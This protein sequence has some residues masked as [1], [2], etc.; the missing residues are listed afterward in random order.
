MGFCCRLGDE[1]QLK[2]NVLYESGN[3][4]VVPTIGQMG[5]DGYVLLCSKEH[6]IG[7]GD[8]PK[9]HT[10]ELESV[11]GRIKKV[12]SETYGSE[13]LVF[14]H[15][16]R[17]GCHKGGGCLDHGHLHIIPTSIDIMEFLQ[18]MFKPEEIQDFSRLRE[19]YEAQRSSYMF[20]ETQDNK[21]YVIEVEF[22][23]PS[24]YLRQVLASNMGIKEWDWRVNPDYGTF[25][26]TVNQLKG[27]F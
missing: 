13:V 21:R 5:I 3:F 27:K 12:I 23:I 24:Q 22:P 19:I 20:V 14:E 4:F 18:K 6:H 1:Y 7:M 17:L 25:E 2:K 26:R 15:G 16:P 9:E 11:L 10:S 8:I